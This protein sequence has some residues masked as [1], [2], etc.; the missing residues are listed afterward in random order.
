MSSATAGIE[1]KCFSAD[2]GDS[3]EFRKVHQTPT[4]SSHAY[5]SDIRRDLEKPSVPRSETVCYFKAGFNIH[6]LGVS[7]YRVS[8]SSE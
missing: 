8:D 4:G 3:G 2:L 6:Q 1:L 5:R 7:A